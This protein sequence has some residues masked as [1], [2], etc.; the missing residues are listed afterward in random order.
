MKPLI[1]ITTSG[2]NERETTSPLY[3]TFATLPTLYIEAVRRAGGV[4]VLLPPGDDWRDVLPALGGIVV[5]GGAD[6]NPAC[7]D[8]NAAH[9]S[10]TVLVPD[11]DTAELALTRHLAAESDL[12]VL[13]IC[14]GIQVLNV[15]LGGTLHE[16]LPDVLPQDIH[17]DAAGNW[18]VHDVQ[19]DAGS[20]LAAVMGAAQVRTTSGHHQALR[21]LGEGLEVV[22]TAPDGVIEAVRLRGRDNL[23]AVQWHPEMSAAD[24]PTQQRLF[25]WLARG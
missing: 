6:V 24:D 20:K 14:R 21:Q 11:R 17:R 13:F 15:A 4:P 23:L 12:P 1:G 3:D 18:A 5:S 2:K 10:L 22:A 7:Y 19:V 9:P 8:G 16:H 25:D